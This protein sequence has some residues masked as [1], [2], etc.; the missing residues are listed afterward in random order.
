[1]DNL[2]RI[3]CLS[4]HHFHRQFSSLFGITAFAYI[5]QARMKR[6]SYQLAFKK[7][8]RIIDIAIAN[9]YESSEAFSRAFSQSI[10]LSPSQ[11]RES[12]DW[13]CWDK[14]EEKLKGIRTQRI[15][16]VEGCRLV[17]V[18]E[19]SE[20]RVAAITHVG[21]L[22]LI[23][24]TIKLLNDWC[25]E[26]SIAIEGERIFNIV[27]DDPAITEPD[28][29]TCDICVSIKSSV[30]KNEYGIVEKSIPAGR[31]AVIRHVGSDDNINQAINYLYSQW[32]EGNE[33]ELRDCPIFFERISVFP[34]VP[35]AEVITDIYLPLM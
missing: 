35:E 8:M 10:G 25:D 5:K 34:N 4:K 12:P 7:N 18:V 20:V 21:A 22:Y 15:K 26:N 23:G 14:N 19:F 9:N 27:Y 31:C 17:E 24:N 13:S 29:Y 28:K 32:L 16:P 2:S 11:F 3:A 1:M 33:E 6:A 30:K